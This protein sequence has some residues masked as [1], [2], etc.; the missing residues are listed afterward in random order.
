M[1]PASRSRSAA[2]KHDNAESRWSPSWPRGISRDC[3]GDLPRLAGAIADSEGVP[4]LLV[5]LGRRG[6]RARAADSKA[7]VG[8]AHPGKPG[9]PG[10]PGEQ[11]S[12]NRRRR[13][14]LVPRV[15]RVAAA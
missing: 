3:G 8:V 14:N 15:N 6:S 1:T 10:G 4:R 12:E 13:V 7:I 11:S 9:E 2:G 5:D